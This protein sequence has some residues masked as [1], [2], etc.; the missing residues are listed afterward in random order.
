[1]LRVF[2]IPNAFLFTFGSKGAVLNTKLQ[3]IMDCTKRQNCCTLTSCLR[4]ATV[5]VNC[6]TPC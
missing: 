6:A 2:R 1:M 3:L 4:S 5:P